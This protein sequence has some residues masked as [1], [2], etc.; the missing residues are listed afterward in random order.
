[1]TPPVEFMCHFIN[2]FFT[3]PQ[4][5]K[6]WVW[7]SRS[8]FALFKHPFLRPLS[9]QLLDILEHVED[10]V[11]NVHCSDRSCLSEHL[12]AYFTYIYT[13]NNNTSIGLTTYR[14]PPQSGPRWWW[15]TWILWLLLF[16]LQQVCLP[17]LKKSNDR[18]VSFFMNTGFRF[19]S[20]YDE[21]INL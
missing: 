5:T 20:F 4:V 12:H 9:A 13:H 19:L 6:W 2:L 1:M 15:R 17:I 11:F 8:Y 3:K 16:V 14:G 7:L 10:D 18:N 21:E